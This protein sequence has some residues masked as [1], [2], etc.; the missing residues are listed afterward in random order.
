MTS[1]GKRIQKITLVASL[2]F[3]GI[4]CQSLAQQQ[5][6]ERTITI[7]MSASELLPA[8]LIIF[9]VN[10]N[11]EGE[12]P[13]EAYEIHKKRENLLAE[14]LKEFDIEE[15]DID[16][17]P[18]RMSK[19]QQNNRYNANTETSYT[20]VT[21]QSVSITFSDFSIYE[22]IQVT[23]IENDFDSFNGKFSSTKITEGKEK[24]LITA[25]ESAKEKA[26][27]IAKTSGVT[28]GPVS[29]I[30]FSDHEIGV[31]FRSDGMEMMAMSRDASMMDFS[32]MVSVT[33]NVNI[34]Y[35]IE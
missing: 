18:I 25:I 1:T 7:N 11:A 29:N 5:V 9:N 26:E 19:R 2:M 15:E 21:N 34:S 8:N 10:I 14:L 30:N 35:F 17:Q 27:L 16:Y 3:F 4:S 23:L 33:A 31:P 12:S 6:S 28:L 22:D 20:T 24:A 32:Q 13:Q